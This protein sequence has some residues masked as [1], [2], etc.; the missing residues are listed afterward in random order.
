MASV[1]SK[2]LKVLDGTS[3]VANLCMIHST[4]EAWTCTSKEIKC[5]K[6]VLLAWCTLGFQRI[7]DLQGFNT[8]V[9]II[10]Q[11]SCIWLQ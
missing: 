3:G 5:I 10:I 9:T 7:I 6:A 4:V 8:T 1:A 2:W 11:I